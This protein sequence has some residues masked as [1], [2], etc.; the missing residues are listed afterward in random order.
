MAPVLTYSTIQVNVIYMS[1]QSSDRYHLKV[2]SVL[3]ITSLNS[4][5]MFSLIYDSLWGVHDFNQSLCKI[6]EFVSLGT[7]FTD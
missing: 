3:F 1:N 5:I 6:T 2:K 4:Y 7:M